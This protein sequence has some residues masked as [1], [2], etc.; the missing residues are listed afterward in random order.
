LASSWKLA[1]T[2]RTGAY[3][4]MSLRVNSDN[5]A[6]ALADSAG[7]GS[8]LKLVLISAAS[9]V[10]SERTESRTILE[11]SPSRM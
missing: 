5:C 8:L 9:E 10:S 6:V 4:D 2:L 3:K 7:C 1:S 11:S